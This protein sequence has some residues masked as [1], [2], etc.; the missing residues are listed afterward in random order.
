MSFQ[1]LRRDGES[2][3][4]EKYTWGVRTNTEKKG[5][6][7]ITHTFFVN[8]LII[9][10]SSGSCLEKVNNGKI[11]HTKSQVDEFKF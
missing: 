3:G 7:F 2:R 9:L 5:L 10:R 4:S 8:T 1:G 11:L 6:Y